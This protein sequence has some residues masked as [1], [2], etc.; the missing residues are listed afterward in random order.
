MLARGQVSLGILAGGQGR[1][2]AGADKAF[3]EF[4]GKSLIS[5]TRSSLGEGFAQVLVSYNGYDQR[6]FDEEARVVPD[7]RAGYPGPLAG[8]ESLLQAAGSEWLLTVPV[9]L[10]DIPP[11]LPETM[12]QAIDASGAGEARPRRGLAVTDADGLQP[13][14]ALWPVRESMAA[15]KLALDAGNHAAHQLLHAMQFS[16]CDISPWR[17][18]NLNAPPDFE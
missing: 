16:I 4:L 5:R 9:D 17:L 6:I 15:T 13:L 2:L 1:R 3:V 11:D 8:L 14:V 12:S 18:G 7:L 10:R